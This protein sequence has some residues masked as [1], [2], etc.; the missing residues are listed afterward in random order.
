MSRPSVWSTLWKNMI[1][2][3]T[4]GQ[5][6]EYVAEDEFG[7]KFYVIKEGKHSKTRGYEAP[8]NGKVTE[9]TKEWVSWLKGTRRFP[10]SENEL[11]LNRIRQ[12]AQLER[13]NILEK[14]MP[15]VDST[16]ETKS[17][18]NSTFPKYDDFEVSPGYNPNKK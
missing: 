17:Q 2:R 15:N 13:N 9:P 5:K 6:R 3:A 14:S 1:A 18:K 10:P 11:A 8:M 7:N 4:G 16:G 12:Q